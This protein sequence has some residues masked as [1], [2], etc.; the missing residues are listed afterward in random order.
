M[1]KL[2]N[3]A[4]RRVV[5]TNLGIA[6]PDIIIGPRVGEDAAVVRVG[7]KYLVMHTDPITGA[8][9]GVGWFAINIVANDIAVRGVKPRWFLLTLLLPRN[10]GED[11]I[12]VIMSDVNRALIELGGSLVGGHT[13]YTPGIDRVIASTTAI[14]IGNR[15]VTT[16]GAKPGDL[17]LITKYV[18]L[19]GTAVL[20]NDFG[21]EL[22]G[23]GVS[24]EIINRARAFLREISV[25]KEALE[26]ADIANSMHDPTEGGLLQGLLEVAEA[27]NV[28]L[29]I[30]ID[31][32]P[33]LPETRLIFNALGIDPLKSLSSG[34]LIATVPRN[35]VEVAMNRLEKLGIN[36][37]VI[38]EVVNGEPGIELIS[39]G[40]VLEEVHGFIEDEVMRLWHLKYG[41]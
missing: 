5:F 10:V 14:G 8:V 17:V 7:D 41:E 20:A 22:M 19:E 13:E 33:I 24:K 39:N 9:E 26:I 29:R 15:Y 36:Y 32:I 35:Q 34:T 3:E 28:R 37:S 12:R 30:N 23:K 1:V 11:G 16:S 21:E 38:G 18:A 27:S 2:S 31:K 6:D 4:L 25:V 40:R